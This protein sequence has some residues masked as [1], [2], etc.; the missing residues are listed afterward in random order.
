MKN[1]EIE[2]E[3]STDYKLSYSLLRSD[4]A[5]IGFV[6]VEING[7]T[8]MDSSKQVLVSY[9]RNAKSFFLGLTF[10]ESD[11]INFDKLC[12]I[13]NIRLFDLKHITY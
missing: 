4:I 7:V 3:L 8:N 2:Y 10:F 1:T 6:A 13:F 5:I 12:E 9:N 11:K